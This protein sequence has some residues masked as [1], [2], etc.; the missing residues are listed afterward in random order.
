ME[1]K[2]S[3]WWRQWQ[4][5][6]LLVLFLLSLRIFSAAITGAKRTFTALEH[7]RSRPLRSLSDP[8]LG[9]AIYRGRL[10]GPSGRVN[11]DGEPSA[12]WEARVEHTTRNG[13]RT[14]TVLDCER[15]EHT[16]VN[17]GDGTASVPLSLLGAVPLSHSTLC[18][19][20]WLIDSGPRQVLRSAVPHTPM[21]CGNRHMFSYGSIAPTTEVFVSGCR[22]STGITK[23]MDGFDLISPRPPS[24]VFQQRL[25]SEGSD[26]ALS[27]LLP[28]ATLLGFAWS[29]FLYRKTLPVVSSEPVSQ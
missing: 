19:P 13:N 3:S 10:E 15:A 9:P 29:I 12:L 26:L 18:S 22:S 5:Q 21:P 24:R 7:Y 11:P 1:W 2:R 25:A 4:T 8:T 27:S 28:L 20:G 14:T 17:L 23:C 6:L 16:D